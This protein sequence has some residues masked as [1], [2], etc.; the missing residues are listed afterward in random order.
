MTAIPMN[1]ESTAYA[2]VTVEIRPSWLRPESLDEEGLAVM[3]KDPRWRT[4][5]VSMPRLVFRGRQKPS[6][7]TAPQWRDAIGD[8]LKF[9]A[10]K[11]NDAYAAWLAATKNR[12]NGDHPFYERDRSTPF[13]MDADEI[14]SVTPGIVDLARTTGPLNLQDYIID[15]PPAEFE[16]PLLLWSWAANSMRQIFSIKGDLK[17][18]GE[19]IIGHLQ[20]VMT[21]RGFRVRPA[22]LE[23]ALIYYAAEMASQGAE[24]HTCRHC[25]GVFLRGGRRGGARKAGAEDCSPQCHVDYN[26]ARKQAARRKK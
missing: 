1:F 2:S 7:L 26:N 14:A 22:R 23:S 21:P 20:M 16:E 17:I 10:P 9:R 6:R 8:L 5:V 13:V 4:S 3:E 19:Q 25:G 11:L 12:D 15:E 18:F 24:S